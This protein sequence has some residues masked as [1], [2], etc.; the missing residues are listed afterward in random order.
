MQSGHF[1]ELPSDNRVCG[2]ESAFIMSRSLI[3]DPKG[4]LGRLPV[5]KRSESEAFFPGHQLPNPS[6]I[7]IEWTLIL[8]LFLGDASGSCVHVHLTMSGDLANRGSS[9]R[10]RPNFSQEEQKITAWTADR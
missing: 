2:I 10:S 7:L 4:L 1:T 5:D 3:K 8:G 6:R 9:R